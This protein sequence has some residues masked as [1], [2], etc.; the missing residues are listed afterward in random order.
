MYVLIDLAKQWTMLHYH[1]FAVVH[2][3]TE[4]PM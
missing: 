1:Q 4:Y 2:E 3:V